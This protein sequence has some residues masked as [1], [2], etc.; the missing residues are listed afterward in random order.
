MK[1]ISR[2][3]FGVFF[4]LIA[5][6][7]ARADTLLPGFDQILSQK[8]CQ[9]AQKD[10]VEALRVSLKKHQNEAKGPAAFQKRLEELL[11][12]EIKTGKDSP[13]LNWIRAVDPWLLPTDFPTRP[14]F[15]RCAAELRTFSDTRL[16]SAVG[17]WN[18]CVA[19]LYPKTPPPEFESIRKCLTAVPHTP[20]KQILPTTRKKAAPSAAKSAEPR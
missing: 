9:D 11:A 2:T 20:S 8:L 15:M 6:E 4:L 12:Q 16:D 14:G 13:D 10:P 18:E 1:S 3:I 17:E 19:S 7:S 5:F